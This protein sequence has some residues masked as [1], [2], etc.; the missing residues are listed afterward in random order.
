MNF[1]VDIADLDNG[2]TGLTVSKPWP[3]GTLHEEGTMTNVASDHL[4][5]DDQLSP[6]GVDMWHLADGRVYIEMHAPD[7]D[8]DLYLQQSQKPSSKT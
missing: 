4:H 3:L 5:M 1:S 2:K 8:T 6:R 7:G